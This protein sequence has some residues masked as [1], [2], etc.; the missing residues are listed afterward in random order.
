MVLIFLH[1]FLRSL[2][3][4][5]LSV[6]LSWSLP[7]ISS[8][9]D[10]PHLAGQALTRGCSWSCSRSLA[11]LP[12]LVFV[13]A[14]V[15]VIVCIQPLTRPL[16]YRRHNQHGRLW[17]HL[18]GRAPSPRRRHGRGGA[19]LSAADVDTQ[20][21]RRRWRREPHAARCLVPGALLC[22]F[23]LLV[24]C[25][26][27]LAGLFCLTKTAFFHLELLSV[28]PDRTRLS[29]LRSSVVQSIKSALV[30]TV[31][32][33]C[34][35]D[36]QPHDRL[37][38]A[39]TCIGFAWLRARLGTVSSRSSG[40]AS[41]ASAPPKRGGCSTSL[42]LTAPAKS[43]GAPPTARPSS[44]GESSRCDRKR[45]RDLAWLRLGDSV[46]NADVDLGPQG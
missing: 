44:C 4:S 43:I 42:T 27:A 46:S 12:V 39:D 6:S 11:L 17:Q 38:D 21:A 32:C 29:S 19:L 1:S 7:C 20:Q 36:P 16:C 45:G 33:F 23:C 14:L 40:R 15:L 13:L 5:F 22:G 8:A 26:V 25:G 9:F 24:P 30:L 18:P 41:K 3:S 10:L 31:F 2:L 34:W 35:R 28:L 37:T